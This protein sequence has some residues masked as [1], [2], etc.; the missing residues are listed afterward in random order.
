MKLMYFK[1]ENY[2]KISCLAAKKKKGRIF[3]MFYFLWNLSNTACTSIKIMSGILLCLLYVFIV[4]SSK[5]P[6]KP[7]RYPIINLWQWLAAFRIN[8]IGISVKIKMWLLLQ[9]FKK[10]KFQSRLSMM[11]LWIQVWWKKITLLI[12]SIVLGS[13]KN[14]LY[15]VSHDSTYVSTL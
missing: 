4:L 10:N 2:C 12:L 14:M 7:W 9:F 5:G 1:N 13:F 8:L 6:P 3:G 15:N 11:H